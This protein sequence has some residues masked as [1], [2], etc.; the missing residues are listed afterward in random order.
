M[1]DALSAQMNDIQGKHKGVKA[2]KLLIYVG[3]G[4]L[5]AAGSVPWAVLGG[6]FNNIVSWS[7]MGEKFDAMASVAWHTEAGKC[8]GENENQGPWRIIPG[9]W[10]VLSWDK[11][12]DLL[13]RMVEN[14][15]D[16]ASLPSGFTSEDIARKLLPPKNR[17]GGAK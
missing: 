17:E 14:A 2:E 9:Y 6:M 5:A 8:V 12:L 4:T 16:Y 15:A 10:G 13:Q 7:C 11:A 1:A 3:H